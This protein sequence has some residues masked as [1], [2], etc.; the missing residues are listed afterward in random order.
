LTSALDGGEWSASCPGCFTPR[1]RAS[2]THWTGGWVGPRALLD[3]LVKRKILSP[4]QELNPDHPACSPE[5]YQLSYHSS[6]TQKTISE[7][8]KCILSKKTFL[9]FS[10]CPLNFLTGVKM[11]SIRK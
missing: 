9:T 7:K 3:E 2:N 4:H 10:T 1:E 11:Q 6:I 5:L 8:S